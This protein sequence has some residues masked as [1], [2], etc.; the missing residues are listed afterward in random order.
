MAEEALILAEWLYATTDGKTA[1]GLVGKSLRYKIVGVIESMLA[2][3]D[4][5]EMLDGKPCGIKIY[6]SLREALRERPR[7][8]GSS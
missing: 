2:G 6:I 5:G 4:A 8:S 3:R 7:P 1:H